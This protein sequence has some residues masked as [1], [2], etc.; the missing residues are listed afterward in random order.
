MMIHSHLIGRPEMISIE[1]IVTSLVVVLIPGTGVIYTVSTALFQGFRKSMAAALGCTLGI[2]PHLLACMLG[3][4]ALIHASALAFQVVKYAGV[5]YL[6]YLA[7]GMWKDAGSIEFGQAPSGHSDFNIIIKGILIN[8][9]NP[10]L[11][12]FFLAFLP[13]FINPSFGALLFQLATLSLIFM[14]M[15]LVVFLLYGFFAHKVR[16]YVLS[17]A[18]AVRW[19]KRSFALC[20]ATLGLKLASEK[21]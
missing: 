11:S 19:M 8:I 18:G 16:R 12:I 4:S 13:Q 5:I 2:V 10:K 14:G 3:I 21:A 9:L 20:F 17:S 7:Y 1:F 6:F 15:T